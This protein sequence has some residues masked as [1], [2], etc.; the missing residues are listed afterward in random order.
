MS[1]KTALSKIVTRFAKWGPL[2]MGMTLDAV[3]PQLLAS[4]AFWAELEGDLVARVRRCREKYVEG[5]A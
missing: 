1:R 2:V 5:R 3:P 4:D